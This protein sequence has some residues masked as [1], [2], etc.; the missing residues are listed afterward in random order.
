MSVNIYPSYHSR[1]S[2]CLDANTN[3]DEYREDLTELFLQFGED[4]MF[5]CVVFRVR[6]GIS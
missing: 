5:A 2:N 3:V 6:F 1:L 4:F